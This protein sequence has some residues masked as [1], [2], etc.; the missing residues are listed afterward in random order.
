MSPHEKEREQEDAHPNTESH[1]T[2]SLHLCFFWP[3][4]D[5]IQLFKFNCPVG[6]MMHIEKQRCRDGVG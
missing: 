4:A 6:K 1:P 5:C 3:I 2:P